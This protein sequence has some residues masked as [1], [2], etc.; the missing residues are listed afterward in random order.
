MKIALRCP[1]NSP[2]CISATLIPVIYDKNAVETSFN[3]TVNYLKTL[4][5]S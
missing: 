3:Y 1:F 5:K 4:F 2:L